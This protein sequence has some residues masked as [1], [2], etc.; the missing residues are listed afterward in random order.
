[1]IGRLLDKAFGAALSPVVDA[2]SRSLP[3]S[4]TPDQKAARK[5]AL[6]E[7]SRMELD[8][9]YGEHRRKGTDPNKDLRVINRLKLLGT[10]DTPAAPAPHGETAPAGFKIPTLTVVAGTDLP[11]TELA[12]AA[13][14]STSHALPAPAPAPA[15]HLREVAVRALPAKPANFGDFLAS[16][17][18]EP[19]LGYYTARDGERVIIT[20][21][22]EKGLF[23]AATNRSGKGVSA[24]GLN[25]ICHKTGSFV[26]T[27][28]KSENSK[29]YA[30]WRHIVLKQKV[31]V[32]DP[33][34]SM[35]DADIPPL[36][37]PGESRRAGYNPI[38]MI[39]TSKHPVADAKMLASAFIPVQ[40]TTPFWS[41]KAQSFFAAYMA[42]VALHPDYDK[43]RT[44][45]SVWEDLTLSSEA[46]F[47]GTPAK[48]ATKD[49]P[50]LS[51]KPGIIHV[52]LQARA[53][54]DLVRA[55]A[56]D[57]LEGAVDTVKGY[58][59]TLRAQA[60]RVLDDPQILDCLSHT[61]LD[62]GLLQREPISVFFVLPG[63]ASE[64]YAN[65]FRVLLS[66]MFTE[67]ERQG[68]PEPGVKRPKTLII[69]DEFATLRR[70]EFIREAVPR[71][72][73]YS[74]QF[75]PF[76]QDLGQLKIYEQGWETFTANAGVL[77]TFGGT[78]DDLTA[79]YFSKKTGTISAPTTSDNYQV[80]GSG[81]GRTIS[82]TGRP[83]LFPYEIAN[84][85]KDDDLRQLLIFTGKGW[86]FAS[87]LTT[88]GDIPE[89]VRFYELQ[90]RLRD[91][92]A[93]TGQ[94]INPSDFQ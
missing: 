94:P 63:W 57:F 56:K 40:G 50:A 60:G 9:L 88:Y 38:D 61:S 1:M 8:Y 33:L 16:M 58:Q 15:P 3:P 70:A 47:L 82:E 32:F 17:P 25:A 65:F 64:V 11:R 46:E 22:G 67:I 12:S 44:M 21:P 77:Q 86:M 55:E 52:M 13:M 54:P 43:P 51:A 18:D 93:E 75:W 23:T 26:C 7:K 36:P 14:L 31:F 5:E 24:I 30:W 49:R 81:G 79:E 87:R 90:K 91:R 39:R 72:P 85:N 76:V 27:D 68:I 4:E 41:E 92:S 45:R 37:F 66:C 2:I 71:L 69:L 89:Y 53:C 84:M 29:L 42:F 59:Q 78:G 34:H 48:A 74:V 35:N 28:P 10:D 19:I 80:K 73:G 20:Y 6:Q 83:A 62:F